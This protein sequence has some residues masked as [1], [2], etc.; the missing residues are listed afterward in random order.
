MGSAEP[1]KPM[2][3]APLSPTYYMERGAKAI[4]A[5]K[6]QSKLFTLNMTKG[7]LRVDTSV[8]ICY[9]LYTRQLDKGYMK[10]TLSSLKLREFNPIQIN[11]KMFCIQGE[12]I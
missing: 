3:T 7:F 1:I 9:N 4:H 2:P 6:F 8:V 12:G 5:K 11:S 10:S